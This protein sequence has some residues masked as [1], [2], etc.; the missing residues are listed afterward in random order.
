[1]LGGGTL[2]FGVLGL[3]APV[4]LARML[5]SDEETA[6][7]IGLRDVGN[8]LAFVLAPTS[9][10]AAQ[11]MLYDL[12]DAL[13]FGPRRPSVAAG[14]LSFAVLAAWTAWRSR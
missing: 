6:R 5:D 14:A 3:V 1:V 9:A 4:R 10:A 2:A 8:A 12:G 11:R 13:A 7:A